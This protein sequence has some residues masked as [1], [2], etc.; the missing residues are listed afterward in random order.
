MKNQLILYKILNNSILNNNNIKN[1]Y[2][3]EE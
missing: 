1:N 2:Y 3:D